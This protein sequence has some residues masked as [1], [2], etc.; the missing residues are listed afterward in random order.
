MDVNETV[1]TVTATDFLAEVKSNLLRIEPIELFHKITE[2]SDE[3]EDV[4]A[5]NIK[6]Y[7]V[8]NL[9][10]PVDALVSKGMSDSQQGVITQYRNKSYEYLE[11]VSLHRRRLELFENFAND[12]NGVINSLVMLKTKDEKAGR[13]GV[14]KSLDGEERRK[15]VFKA[16]WMEEIVTR[17]D[18]KNAFSQATKDAERIAE[19]RAKRQKES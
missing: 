16:P 8:E 3:L 17:I 6:T 4:T 1:G 9:K 18:L 14:S 11:Q 10:S 12:P 5:I 15:D 19:E 7:V 13:F 2:S